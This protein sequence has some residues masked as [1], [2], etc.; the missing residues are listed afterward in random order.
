[1]EV[2]LTGTLHLLEAIRKESPHTLLVHISSSEVY[3]KVLPEEN[4]IREDRPL[5]PL[6]CYGLSKS[7]SEEVVRFYG[8][9]FGIAAVILRPFNHIGP[10]QSDRFVCSSF[11]KQLVTIELGRANPLLHVG[12][13]DPVRD[14]T[15]VRDMVEAYRLAAEHCEPG[16]THNIASGQGLSI[17]DLLGEMRALFDFQI[18]VREDP[19]RVRKTEIPMLV[20][21]AT[22]FRE[23][24]GWQPGFSLSRTLSDTADYWRRM[25]SGP[26]EGDRHRSL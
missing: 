21:D 26:A 19:N 10:R 7:L 25:A 12:N 18:E 13:L 2:N 6:H 15:D 3:G 14:F 4:P 23:K 22:S 9:R 1:M 17:A 16:S 5:A 8:K 11:L 24:T 20:G